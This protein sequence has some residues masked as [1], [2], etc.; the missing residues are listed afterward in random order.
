MY[1]NNFFCKKL[2]WNQGSL[3]FFFSSHPVHFRLVHPLSWEKPIDMWAW[4]L[5][6]AQHFTTSEFQGCYKWRSVSPR[7]NAPHLRQLQRAKDDLTA[8]A[9]NVFLTLG[10]VVPRELAWQVGGI[11]MLSKALARPR[12]TPRHPWSSGGHVEPSGSQQQS[13]DPPGDSWWHL[14]TLQSHQGR[15]TWTLSD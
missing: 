1:K 3:W 8:G 7:E 15:V 10:R 9:L 14:R 12:H 6:I 5:I 4:G 11:Q 13:S 2:N